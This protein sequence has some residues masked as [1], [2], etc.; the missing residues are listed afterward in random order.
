MQKLENNVRSDSQLIAT[1]VCSQIGHKWNAMFESHVVTSVD[2]TSFY[3]QMERFLEQSAFVNN[4]LM[5]YWSTIHSLI[6]EICPKFQV[7]ISHFFKVDELLDEH[8]AKIVL[9]EIISTPI[10]VECYWMYWVFKTSHIIRVAFR[11]W[12]WYST[13]RILELQSCM[14]KNL[15]Q[16]V[17]YYESYTLFLE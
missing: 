10:Y 16:V 9:S 17:I 3:F 8:W 6:P 4:H 14:Q 12:P 2:R 13:W 5:C 15:L 1:E 11:V 7:L